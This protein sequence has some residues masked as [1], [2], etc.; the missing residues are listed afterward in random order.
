M[1]VWHAAWMLLLTFAPAATASNVDLSTVPKRDTVSAH[2]LQQ[3]RPDAR[4]R[5]ANDHL[6]ERR[7]PAAVLVGQHAH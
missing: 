6:Q 3:R 1:K 5:N 4:A 7:Q 2:D